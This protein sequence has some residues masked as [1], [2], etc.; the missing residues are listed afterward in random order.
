MFISDEYCSN[1]GTGLTMRLGFYIS[2]NI[3]ERSTNTLLENY[4]ITLM[5]ES[6]SELNIYAILIQF[7]FPR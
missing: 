1:A 3:T 7:L 4:I 5:S 2:L 6:V